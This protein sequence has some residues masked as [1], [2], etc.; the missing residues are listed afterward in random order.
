[1][2]LRFRAYGQVPQEHEPPWRTSQRD[3]SAANDAAGAGCADRHHPLHPATRRLGRCVFL[4]SFRLCFV[5]GI[6]D[7]T[8][9]LSPPELRFSLGL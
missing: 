7:V 1:M 6:L 4:W 2:G 8:V 3:G 9:V 5:L